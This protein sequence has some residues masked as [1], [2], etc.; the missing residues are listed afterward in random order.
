MDVS[1]NK[2]NN[3]QGAMRHDV[4]DNSSLEPRL[5]L[6]SLHTLHRNLSI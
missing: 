5:A 4:T 6:I 1:L 2:A 3:T